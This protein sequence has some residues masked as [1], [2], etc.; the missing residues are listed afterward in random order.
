[1]R[2]PVAPLSRSLSPLALIFCLLALSVSACAESTSDV[3]ERDDP[4]PIETEVEEPI[5]FTGEQYPASLSGPN[6]IADVVNLIDFDAF[7]WTAFSPDHPY[8]IQG[9]CDI[10][11]NGD[12]NTVTVPELPMEIQGV[13]TY[14]P[15]HFYK[16]ATCGSDERFYGSFVI[17]DGTD[18]IFVLRDSRISPFS[19][20]DVV[21]MRV[22]GL[23][24][25]FD[26]YAILT[27][28]NLEVVEGDKRAIW[29]DNTSGAFTPDDYGQVRRIR[30]EII[31]EA[32]NNNF[33]EMEIQ[34]LDDPTVTWLASLD[35]ELGQRRPELGVGTR[36]QLTG[37]VIDSFGLRMLVA[38][39]GQIERLD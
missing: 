14:H 7:V 23:V 30:G 28:D 10:S 3:P 9:D 26:T 35:R 24:K 32:T 11:R 6:T 34:S 18:G 38:S 4:E 22:T 19:Y 1:M 21:K 27:H 39:F 29:F 31:S 25:F 8:P 13:V 5:A 33:N 17:Q 16:P 12:Q 15:R 36:I 37:P 20:G 2:Q